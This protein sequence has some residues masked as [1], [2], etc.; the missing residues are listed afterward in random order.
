MFAPHLRH[1]WVDSWLS[2]LSPAF[3]SCFQAVCLAIEVR[4]AL[5]G[6]SSRLFSHRSA[7]VFSGVSW[8]CCT[9]LFL[10][11]LLTV[12]PVFTLNQG[13]YR[14]SQ[15][16]TQW[17]FSLMPTLET[18]TRDSSCFLVV[19]LEHPDPEEPGVK[20]DLC[21]DWIRRFYLKLL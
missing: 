3:L 8:L 18:D 14:N 16:G 4:W 19:C 6:P 15:Q 7:F 5:Q 10:Y 17:R 11:P 13:L 9:D 2:R 12:C 21:S 20:L 1:F